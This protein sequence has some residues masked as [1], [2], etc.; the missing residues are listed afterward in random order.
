MKEWWPITGV[1]NYQFQKSDR[2]IEKIQVKLKDS[3]NAISLINIANFRMFLANAQLNFVEEIESDI[4][5]LL[6][7][8][9]DELD[10]R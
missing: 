7:E 5:G 10:R 6:K 3:D 4:K 2:F 1:E 9:E 8:L